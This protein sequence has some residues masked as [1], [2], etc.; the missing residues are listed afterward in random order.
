MDESLQ[1]NLTTEEK[2]HDT[3]LETTL[4]NLVSYNQEKR[5]L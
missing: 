3:E 1:N 5:T 4:R 2:M